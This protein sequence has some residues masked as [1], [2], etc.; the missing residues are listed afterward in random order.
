MFYS[1][2]KILTYFLQS[3]CVLRM[4]QFKTWSD[5]SNFWL[6]LLVEYLFK[7]W[8]TRNMLSHT[9]LTLIIFKVA[10]NLTQKN[11]QKK[12][13]EYTLVAR[14]IHEPILNIFQIF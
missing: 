8:K 13:Y 4:L 10:F 5:V 6:L 7:S 2:I 1:D 14:N 11:R 12:T 9:V 3:T